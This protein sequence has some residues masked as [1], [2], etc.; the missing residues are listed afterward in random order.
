MDGI[1]NSYIISQ[2]NLN[3]KPTM[4]ENTIWKSDTILKKL[5]SQ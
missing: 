5:K 1:F 2:D 3:C 4:H